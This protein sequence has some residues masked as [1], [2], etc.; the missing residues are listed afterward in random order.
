MKYTVTS[1]KH[2]IEVRNWVVQLADPLVTVNELLANIWKTQITASGIS[3]TMLLLKYGH[4]LGRVTQYKISGMSN[5]YAIYK[6]ANHLGDPLVT[7]G[8]I[9]IDMVKSD[10]VGTITA[11]GSGESMLL[12]KFGTLLEKVL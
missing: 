2:F 5:Y 12:E 10:F 9:N 3:E 6:W 11:S 1:I 7:M 8:E 4:I